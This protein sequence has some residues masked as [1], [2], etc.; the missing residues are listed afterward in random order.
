MQAKLFKFNEIAVVCLVVILPLWA[1]VNATSAN[2]QSASS[3]TSKIENAKDCFEDT[4]TVTVNI[5]GKEYCI[6][7]DD[8]QSNGI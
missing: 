1:C 7:M 8:L 6:P 2:T 4:V 5:T 3:N